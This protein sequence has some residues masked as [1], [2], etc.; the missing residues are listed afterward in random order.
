MGE[1]CPEIDIE[2]QAWL[3]TQN[4]DIFHFLRE[5]KARIKKGENLQFLD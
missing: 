2:H 4:I 3:H 5:C 1:K